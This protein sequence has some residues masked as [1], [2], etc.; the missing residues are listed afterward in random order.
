MSFNLVQMSKDQTDICVSLR[1]VIVT[2]FGELHIVGEPHFPREYIF[3]Q[4]K[5]TL[6]ACRLR[7]KNA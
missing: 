6:T 5:S 1:P 7:I 4:C 3:G 2:G